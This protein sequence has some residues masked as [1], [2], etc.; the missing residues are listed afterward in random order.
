ME[1]TNQICV[2]RHK[3]LFTQEEHGAAC[4][5]W[6]KDWPP[7]RLTPQRAEP[8]DTVTWRYHVMD[9]TWPLHQSVHTSHRRKTAENLSAKL[10]SC[11]H[12]P[13]VWTWPQT[14]NTQTWCDSTKVKSVG[15]NRCRH[16]RF[17]IFRYH[18]HTL[19]LNSCKKKKTQKRVSESVCTYLMFR[20]VEMP[21]S[22]QSRTGT[23][24]CLATDL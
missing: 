24:S 13:L 23:S 5:A 3:N 15:N 22:S 2:A 21:L 14:R 19:N 16:S 4:E 1:S 12:A 18:L 6:K 9:D 20:S 11:L 8:P 10:C 7:S 17:R